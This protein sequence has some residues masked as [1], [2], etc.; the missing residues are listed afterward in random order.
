MKHAFI[1]NPLEGVKPWK[2]TSYFLMLAAYQRGHEVAYLDQRDL[3][4]DHDHLMARFTWLKVHDDHDKPFEI[5]AQSSAGMSD[6]DVVWLRTN[7]PFDRRYFYT[8]LLLT[9]YQ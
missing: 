4:L 7:P 2:D 8:T 3:Y 6:L 1:M 9:I 5:I